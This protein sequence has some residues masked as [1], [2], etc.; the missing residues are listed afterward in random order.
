MKNKLIKTLSL[1]M[2]CLTLTLILNGVMHNILN[3]TLTPSQVHITISPNE[4]AP[5]WENTN[6]NG[7]E[8][9]WPMKKY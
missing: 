9:S 8:L 3:N 1:C 6:N 5:W 4:D 2:S 7:G